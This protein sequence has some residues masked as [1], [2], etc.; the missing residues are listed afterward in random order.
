MQG[1]FTRRW[2]LIFLFFGMLSPYS[3]GQISWAQDALITSFRIAADGRFMLE[4]AANAD[5]YYILLRGDQVSSI[6]T[7]KDLQFGVTERGQLRDPDLPAQAKFYRVRRVPLA[8]P[9]DTDGDGLPDPCEMIYR[10]RLNPLSPDDSSLDPDHDG[11]TTL[12]ECSNRTD[13]FAPEIPAVPVLQPPTNATTA[14]FVM[15]AGRAPTNTLI[16]VEGGA[17]FVTNRVDGTGAFDLTV[18]LVPNRLNRLFVSAVDE[19]GLASPLAPL[20]ILQD[21]TPPYVFIDFPTNHS[22]VASESIVVAGRVGDALSGFLGLAVTVQGQPARV[23]VG[24]GPNGTYE[25]GAV[26]LALGTN[27]INVLATD[28]LGNATPKTVTVIRR[29]PEGARLLAVSGDLQETTIL[30]RLP[31]PLV[32]KL[33]QPGGAPLSNKIVTFQVTRSDGRLLPVSADQLASD[34]AKSPSY[35][36]NGA[37]SFQLRTDANG[38][39]RVWW[40]LGTDAGHANNRVAVSSAETAEAAFFC[41]SA[42]ARPARQINI[43]SGNSQRGET[44][45]PSPEPLKVWVSDGNNPVPGVEVAFRVVLGGGKVVPIVTTNNTSPAGPGLRAASRPS[46][47]IA[48]ARQVEG[49]LPGFAEVKVRTS[50]TGHAEVD[51]IFGPASGNQLIEATFP[52]NAG[53][54]ATFV[55]TGIARVP[56][57]PTSFSGLVQDNSFLPV[58]GAYC[59]LVVAGGTNKTTS[60]AQ[61]RFGFQNIASGSG[62]LYVNGAYAFKLGTNAIP[63]NSFPSLQYTLAIV[64]NAENTLPMPVLLPRLNT[65]NAK[66]YAGTNDLVVTCEGVAGLKMTIKANSMRQPTGELVTPDRPVWVSLNQVHHDKVPMPMPDGASP[67]FAWTLQPGGATFDPPI[68]VEYPNMSG[69][70]PGAAAYFLTFNHDTE[71]FE[72][73]AS[74]HVVEDGSVIKTDLGAGLTISG[75]GCNCPPYSVTGDCVKCPDTVKEQCYTKTYEVVAKTCIPHIEDKIGQP[76]NDGLGF[77]HF[78]K[79]NDLLVCKGRRIACG[80]N[81]LE[82]CVNNPT[83]CLDVLA[84]S[85]A[86]RDDA[87]DYED[88]GIP[89]DKVEAWRHITWQCELAKAFGDEAAR[90]IGD[91]HEVSGILDGNPIEDSV[92]DLHNN[93][94]GRLLPS[95]PSG[96][97]CGDR[98]W[99]IVNGNNPNFDPI[100]DISDPAEMDQAEFPINADCEE[101]EFAAQSFTSLRAAAAGDSLVFEPAEVRLQIGET[102]P[103]RVFL[104]LADGTRTDITS[105]AGLILNMG[106][107]P[108]ARLRPGAVVEGLRAGSG[109]LQAAFRQAGRTI[110][111]VAPVF[112]GTVLDRDG[113][114]LPDALETSL[115]LNPANPRDAASDL[116]GDTLSNIAE[117]RFG[118]RLDL[119]DTDDDGQS[120]AAE[121]SRGADPLQ[122]TLVLD[123]T[124]TFMVN[125]QAGRANPDGSLLLANVS[126]PDSFGPSGPFGPGDF[127]SDDPVRVIGYSTAGGKVRYAASS[128]FRFGSGS[129]TALTDLVLHPGELA[130]PENLAARPD[131][132]ALTAIGAGT[133]IRVTATLA[134]RAP[135]EISASSFGTTYRTSN[136]RIVR[137]D[138]EGRATATGE[139]R[140]LLTAVNE[141]VTAVCEIFVTPGVA[142]TAVTG[143]VLRPDGTPAAGAEVRVGGLLVITLTDENGRFEV[144]GV[145]GTFKR[146]KGWVSSRADNLLATWSDIEALPDGVTDVGTLRLGT[147]RFDVGSVGA[148]GD[149]SAVIKKDGTLWTWGRNN[150]GLLGDGTRVDRFVP[151]RITEDT[152]W[153]GV[154][155][156]GHFLALK[157]NGELWAWGSN[158]DGQ[159]GAG[160]A[161]TFSDRPVRVGSEAAWMTVDAGTLHSLGIKLDGSLWAWGYN[162]S[163]QAGTNLVRGVP[164]RQGEDL[165]WIAVSAGGLH[166]MGLKTDGTLWAW[167]NNQYGQLGVGPQPASLRSTRVG[168]ERDWIG[169]ACG[170]AHT[171]ALKADGTIWG[172]GG[173]G[174]ELGLPVGEPIVAPRRLHESDDWVWVGAKDNYTIA[175]KRDG[176]IWAGGYSNRGQVGNGFPGSRRPFAQVGSRT[177]WVEA[178]PGHD[179]AL[180]L[181][182]DGTLWAWGRP[183]LLG[184][185]DYIYYLTPSR[186]DSE[187]GSETNWAAITAGGAHTLALKRDGTLWGSGSSEQGQLGDGVPRE[188]GISRIRVGL[189]PLT[190]GE[191]WLSVAAGST[192]TL[193]IRQ[194]GS[195]WAWGD[196]QYG[197][198]GDGT[199][200]LRVAPVRILDGGVAAVVAG[201]SHSLARLASGEVFAWANEFGA[202]LGNGGAPCPAPCPGPPGLWAALAAG[203]LHTLGLRPDGTLWAWGLNDSGQLGNEDSFNVVQPVQIGADNNWSQ[204]SA[205]D[206]HSLALRVDGSLWAWGDQSSGQ[207]GLGVAFGPPVYVPTRVG[208]E[209]DWAAIASGPSHNLALKRD[210]TLWSWGDNFSGQLGIGTRG[211]EQYQTSPVRVGNLAGWRAIA[212]GGGHG[213]ALRED[214]TL[215]SW[216]DNSVGQ[217]GFDPIVE[218]GRANGTAGNWGVLKP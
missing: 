217:L 100:V 46:G 197:Q 172:W 206:Q 44:L 107:S 200:D 89:S 139:G 37:L 165:D 66:W 83:I 62:H 158:F 82:W 59:E 202:R 61:G 187:T 108:V 196:N 98:A 127:L 122:P 21:S 112:V 8:N 201:R 101:A 14:S 28:R 166:S 181:A 163:G 24:I 34:P 155:A 169:V 72:I 25:R 4:H 103:V 142:T 154:S 35:T 104:R 193:G 140:A 180:A 159:L 22:V 178:S 7:P 120:D 69:L 157:Q 168:L 54:P 191:T 209:N 75:W 52:G 143:I 161:L 170:N 121:L 179:H 53:L 138:G 81:E 30:R 23:D 56:G 192:H 45:G 74:G 115:G 67:P 213:L 130:I 71:R 171:V 215:W 212:A 198:L 136:E 77:T 51:F 148:G 94:I 96:Q 195:V 134:G 211:I 50:I 208:Q 93:R 65:N 150:G 70:A 218:V 118:T 145:P 29:I 49:A 58:A 17:A 73:V 207:L 9:L 102:A 36:T 13:P 133:Q 88:Q 151:E 11:R 176:T 63:T 119:P 87:F 1:A 57:Q 152:N 188:P 33:A 141:G 214:G 78:D 85:E 174:I 153:A 106:D 113:D 204:I 84:L 144:L 18:P 109:R 128:R 162:A 97:S 10:P 91:A 164:A 15:F 99:D 76:C 135:R 5:S 173:N 80:E 156:G 90:E 147:A 38:E 19:F 167:G 26:P 42:L 105:A 12:E 199:S 39:A 177:D 129:V 55:L 203:N 183:D 68:A 132:V 131:A 48:L 182:A 92:R 40:T 43:G 210:G 184:S 86:I 2:V 27:V 137:V 149:A 160:I 125:G 185:G 205:G 124:W 32:V 189:S 110:S 194:D 60:D 47:S 79:C 190:P 16:R 116:D 64:P 6:A 216:G 41:A 3:P 186:V 114:G 126:S 117:H 20:D 95:F 146:L 175:R 123:E 31:A 111:S